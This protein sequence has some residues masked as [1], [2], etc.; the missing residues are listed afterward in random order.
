MAQSKASGM[1]WS[2]SGKRS[3]Y[4]LLL[5]AF[6]HAGSKFR[7]Y[8]FSVHQQLN[9]LLQLKV[10]DDDTFVYKLAFFGFVFT[11]YFS[12]PFCKG[13]INFI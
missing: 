5:I 6:L 10:Y 11:T 12:V 7:V 13:Q 9:M 2:N 8:F 1:F 4:P 3:N